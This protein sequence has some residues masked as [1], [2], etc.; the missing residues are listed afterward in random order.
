MVSIKVMQK[1]HYKPVF[2]T[3]DLITKGN[4]LDPHRTSGLLEVLEMRIN[5]IYVND[6]RSAFFLAL[7]PPFYMLSKFC[8]NS[9]EF[10]WYLLMSATYLANIQPF[11]P[12]YNV[13]C[14]YCIFK[15]CVM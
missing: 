2:N 3:V 11:R 4:L 10:T 5:G 7:S 14:K 9:T 13:S 6:D 12:K 1:F 15:C 8:Q